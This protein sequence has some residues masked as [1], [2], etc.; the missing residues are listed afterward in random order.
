MHTP[1]TL[2]KT[3]GKSRPIH[4]SASAIKAFL[5]CPNCFRY[6]YIEGVRPVDETETQRV[7]THWHKLHEMYRDQRA[8]ADHDQSFAAALEWLHGIYGHVPD[9]RDATEWEIEYQ[10]LVN[11]FA[12][13]MWYYQNDHIETLATELP[14]KLPVFHPKTGLPLRLDEVCTVGKIDRFIRTG[15]N[16]VCISDY[17]S[18]SKPIAPD[19]DFWGHLRL[20]SQLSIYVMSAQDMQKNGLLDFCQEGDEIV[21]AYYDVWHRPQIKPSVLSQKDT[22]AVIDSGEYLGTKFQV[23]VTLHP[24]PSEQNKHLISVD[25]VACDV[26]MGKK[27]FAIRENPRMFGARLLADI[28]NRPDFYFQRREVP[29]TDQDIRNFRRELYG[30]YQTIKM[31]RDGNW[32]W[33]NDQ[34]DSMVTHGDYGQLCYFNVDVSNGQTPPGFKRIFGETHEPSA[35]TDAAP[36]A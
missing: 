13:Y 9:N 1:E 10:I 21:G 29:R 23:V 12:G 20:D 19:S 7:G 11:S 5:H 17:K 31:M 33:R 4:L 30:I 18:T 28:Y 24:D 16:R 14:F 3:A 32:W 36:A 22:A 2:T 25:G 27:G 6:A 8:A 34:Q 35:E 15:P 26:E